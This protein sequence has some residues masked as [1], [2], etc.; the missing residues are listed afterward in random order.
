MP[1]TPQV[2]QYRIVINMPA[3]SEIQGSFLGHFFGTVWTIVSTFFGTTWFLTTS[4]FGA[5]FRVVLPATVACIII[6]GVLFAAF[7]AVLSIADWMGW[8]KLKPI[9]EKQKARHSSK[10]DEE[11][12]DE[13]FVDVS[14]DKK[15]VEVE[16]EFLEE[17]LRVR[18]EKL[19]KLD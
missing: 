3:T 5:I 2:F 13:V 17:L 19:K 12:P 18:R 8:I 1:R 11:G 6:C 4:F 15:R 10:P 7:V 16:I 14:S 9:V